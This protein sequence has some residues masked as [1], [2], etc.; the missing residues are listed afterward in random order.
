MGFF[1]EFQGR[2]DPW[3]AEYGPELAAVALISG[4]RCVGR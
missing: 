1:G 2:I 3:Q 4:P